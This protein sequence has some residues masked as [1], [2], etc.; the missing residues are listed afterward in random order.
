MSTALDMINKLNG[1]KNVPE[2]S[3]ASTAGTWGDLGDNGINQQ[4]DWYLPV[5]DGKV[6]LSPIAEALHIDPELTLIRR[7]DVQI[8]FAI[9]AKNGEWISVGMGFKQSYAVEKIFAKCTSIDS[10]RQRLA[11]VA[12]LIALQKWLETHPEGGNWE[13]KGS[14][15]FIR[16]VKSNEPQKEVQADVDF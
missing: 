4:S 12:L 6:P 10:A 9:Q 5:I 8:E 14:H 11:R 3:L 15:F 1:D 16:K 13:F 7:D 2:V